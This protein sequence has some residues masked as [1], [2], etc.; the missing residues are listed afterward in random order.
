MRPVASE[1]VRA[2]KSNSQWGN[3]EDRMSF[4]NFSSKCNYRSINRLISRSKSDRL[5]SLPH[6]RNYKKRLNFQRTCDL[7]GSPIVNCSSMPSLFLMRQTS[8]CSSLSELSIYV[9]CIIRAG[10]HTF[11]FSLLAHTYAPSF[12]DS[13]PSHLGLIP[14]PFVPSLPL[15]SPPL[16]SP[17]LTSPPHPSPPLLCRFTRRFLIFSLSERAR[18]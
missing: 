12:C 14:S 18:E 1:T 11:L 7:L 4:G 10:K 15:P 3:R 17:P 13:N 5:R 2:L 6:L 16:P 8:L 9:Y